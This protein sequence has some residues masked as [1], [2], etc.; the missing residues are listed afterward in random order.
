ME[1]NSHLYDDQEAK[2]GPDPAVEEETSS[3]PK[4]VPKKDPVSRTIMDLSPE[5]YARLQLEV[6]RAAQSEVDSVE[7][8]RRKAAAEAEKKRQQVEEAARLAKIRANTLLP[9]D[10][11]FGYMSMFTRRRFTG[12]LI[13]AAFIAWCVYVLWQGFL[14]NNVI[15]PSTALPEAVVLLYGLM[16]VML[17]IVAVFNLLV[18]V[19][20]FK[21]DRLKVKDGVL[22]Y[23]PAR[24][25]WLFMFG[26]E[27]ST[28]SIVLSQA[29]T[30]DF[31]QNPI[32]NVFNM[33]STS[34]VLDTAADE[35]DV[36]KKL[37]GV[38]HSTLLK[39]H[40]AK[41]QIR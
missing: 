28:K 20:H 32:E 33:D 13:L 38:K 29:G 4:K 23:V 41:A 2:K 31:H 21:R 9:Y 7:E 37:R 25:L 26:G 15:D 40:I 14:G 10:F 36:F 17:T 3:K 24:V 1:D 35:N 39:A 5:E 8:K 22:T 30:P 12:S 16:L 27:K 11:E 18:I 19:M 6:L 34:L